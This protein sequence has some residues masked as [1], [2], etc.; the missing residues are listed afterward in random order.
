MS[1]SS[2]GDVGALKIKFQEEFGDDPKLWER[3]NRHMQLAAKG[4]YHTTTVS[5]QKFFTDPYYCGKDL[6]GTLFPA[7]L[8]ALSET[9][10]GRYVEAV[11][12]GGIGCSKTTIALLGTMYQIYVLSC[13]HN[14]Q[15][16]FGLHQTDEIVFIFQSLA[17][18]LAKDVS[19]DR[20][21]A[22]LEESP[23]FQAKF[24]HNKDLKSVIAFPNRIIVKAVA[25]YFH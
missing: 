10:S 7:V 16:A 23:Y 20:F 5:P 8:E 1:F 2:V 22:R 12:T 6:A 14:P 4:V 13:M 17:A 11:L 24:P 25:Q 9:C 3:F 15:R 18:H 19:F 21:R